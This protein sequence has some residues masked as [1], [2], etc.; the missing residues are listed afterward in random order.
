MSS[1]SEN[2]EFPNTQTG[3]RPGQTSHQARQL[4]PEGRIPFCIQELQF[5][6][7]PQDPYRP[8]AFRQFPAGDL[9]PG[10]MQAELKG[11]APGHPGSVQIGLPCPDE[12]TG[13][14]GSG[15]FHAAVIT[16]FIGNP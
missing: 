4:F 10:M 6:A 13:S 8:E 9:Y 11:S 3:V 12:P 7:T 5:Q 2:T 14:P 1:F 15:L 16:G